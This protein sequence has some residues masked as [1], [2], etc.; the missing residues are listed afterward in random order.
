MVV[1]VVGRGGVFGGEDLAH[2]RGWRL[3]RTRGVAASAMAM[4]PVRADLTFGVD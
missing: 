4:R 2:G 3:V 1:V